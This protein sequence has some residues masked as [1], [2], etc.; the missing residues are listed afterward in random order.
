MR[1]YR[2]INTDKK[3]FI[4]ATLGGGCGTGSLKAIS[5]EFKDSNYKFNLIFLYIFSFSFRNSTH[6]A[7]NSP[8]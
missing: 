4:F 6:F 1:L 3:V 8:I 2:F 5:Q 7:H